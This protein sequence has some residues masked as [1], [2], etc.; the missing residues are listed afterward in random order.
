M[1]NENEPVPTPAPE[2]VAAIHKHAASLVRLGLLTPGG[3]ADVQRALER[4]LGEAQRDR[5]AV[6]DLVDAFLGALAQGLLAPDLFVV[7]D[8]RGSAGVA[9]FHI[10]PVLAVLGEARLLNGFVRSRLRHLLPVVSDWF[11]DSGLS[12]FQ[13]RFTFGVGDRRRGLELD[14]AVGRAFLKR[15]EAVPSR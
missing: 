15:T 2:S 14:L 3:A 12:G 9:T 13:R 5:G 7:D 10:A 8:G 6:A 1:E 11:P 4:A